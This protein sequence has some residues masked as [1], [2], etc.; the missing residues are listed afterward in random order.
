MKRIVLALVA[1]ASILPDAGNALDF[2]IHTNNKSKSLTAI[3]ATGA[4]E[5]GDVERL[6][7]FLRQLTLKRHIAIYLASPGGNLYEGMRL[8]LFLHQNR[9]RTVVEGGYDCASACALA[10]LGG[11]GNDGKPWRSSSTDS[12]LGFHA[13]KGIAGSTFH[14]DEVQS[15]VADMLRYGKTVSAPIDLLIAG[16]STPSEDIFWVSNSDVCSLGIKLWSNETDR[17]VCNN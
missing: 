15:I 13:F 16:F 14:A 7:S 12:R 6:Q 10:F 17:F 1:L 2:S 3:L 11:T 8:G 9:I 5:E 4:V